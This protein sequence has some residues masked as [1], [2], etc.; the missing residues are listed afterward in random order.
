[1][2][3]C[4]LILHL[5]IL[6]NHSQNSSVLATE[7]WAAVSYHDFLTIF[8]TEKSPTRNSWALLNSPISWM[9]LIRVSRS[10]FFSHDQFFLKSNL[11]SSRFA[12]P[13]WASS[14]SN[15]WAKV[16]CWSSLMQMLRDSTLYSCFMSSDLAPASMW[17]LLPSRSD[18]ATIAGL[19]NLYQGSLLLQTCWC[20]EEKSSL[21]ES[22]LDSNYFCLTTMR[23]VSLYL[24]DPVMNW[25]SSFFV[26]SHKLAIVP[27]LLLAPVG[28]VVK[29]A[30]HE[31]VRRPSPI[32]GAVSRCFPLSHKLTLWSTGGRTRVWQ[33]NPR[34]QQDPGIQQAGCLR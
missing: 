22:F 6:R 21:S 5:E 11:L 32:P 7:K 26:Q 25:T 24:S 18:F 15:R 30:E 34:V 16:C 9:L 19:E 20:L 10:A 4:R 1:M 29:P 12:H 13:K 8:C 14:N 17:S 3:H 33:I 28:T 27:H 31:F 2:F 23:Q